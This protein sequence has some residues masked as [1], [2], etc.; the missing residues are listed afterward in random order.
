MSFFCYSAW[1][2]NG[3][4]LESTNRTH[5]VCVCNHLTNF[6]IL[7]DVVDEHQHSLFTMFDGNMRIFIYIS[8]AICVVFIII[9]LLTLK[10][11]NGVFVKVRNANSTQLPHQ[12]T[13][14]SRRQQNNIRDQ[15]HESLTLTTPTGPNNTHS[16]NNNLQQHTNFIQHNSIRNSHRNNLNYNLQQQL[17]QQQQQQQVV[18][19][20]AAAVVLSHSNNNSLNQQ[21]Q[22]GMQMN[23]LNINLHPHGQQSSAAATNT[24]TAAA[25]AAAASI[26]AALQQHAAHVG[27]QAAANA[28]ASNNLNISHNYLQARQQSQQQ[29]Q[30]QQHNQTQHQPHAH[31][32][33]PQ[34][35]HN[36]NVDGSNAM[37][38]NNIIMQANMDD[39]QYKWWWW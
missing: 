8:V 17:Q 39:L 27:A 9:A 29:H 23:N 13:G 14:S 16:N 25:A 31:Q 1:S 15:T 18:A 5:S 22:R 21:P 34:H 26:A 35:N 3:C 20:A 7:M 32:P 6:A 28:A 12:R 33:H 30:Q 11:F 19:A 10:L 24:T 4:S 2:A 36:L 38:A 37:D